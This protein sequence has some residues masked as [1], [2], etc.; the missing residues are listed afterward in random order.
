LGVF[1]LKLSSWTDKSGKN[2]QNMQAFT[3]Y[4]KEAV[5]KPIMYRNQIHS[6]KYSG[7]IQ[8]KNRGRRF[9]FTKA[10]TMCSEVHS[11]LWEV[12]TLSEEIV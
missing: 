9:S 4:Y 8:N 6:L 5:I 10:R 7:I 2:G 12:S 11:I 1:G 3:K